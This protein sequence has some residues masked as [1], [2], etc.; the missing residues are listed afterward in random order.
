MG[1]VYAFVHDIGATWEHYELTSA[2]RIAM[3]PPGLLL[4]VAGPTD[5]GYRI[6]EVWHSEHDWERYRNRP[7][8]PPVA[9]AGSFP[10]P[11]P[12]FRDV[13]ARH[14]VVGDWREGDPVSW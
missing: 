10:A 7:R 6:V 12:V 5:E 9:V 4:H 13:V 14:V 3:R 1:M 11:A 8:Q 2:A